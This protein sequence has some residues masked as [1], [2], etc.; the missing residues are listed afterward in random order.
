MYNF[1]ELLR[2]GSSVPWPE[3]LQQATGRN[4][5]SADALLEYF[6]PLYDWLV[7]ENEG[8][9]I[10]WEE[11]CPEGLIIASDS[12]RLMSFSAICIAFALFIKL[13]MVS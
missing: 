4:T 3:V 9:P 8:H 2:L 1:S 11:D 13:V 10:G 6:Q 5:L 7:R 12:A